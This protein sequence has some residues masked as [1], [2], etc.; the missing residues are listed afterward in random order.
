MFNPQ[1]DPAQ[2]QA[3]SQATGGL[4]DHPLIKYMMEQLA[5]RTGQDIGSSLM[6]PL[7]MATPALDASAGALR[8]SKILNAIIEA[9][10][11]KAPQAI[12]SV[13]EPRLASNRG[14]G[15]VLSR[16]PGFQSSGI[17]SMLQQFMPTQ[18]AMT[19]ARGAPWVLGREIGGPTAM[20][21]QPM[22]ES[23]KVASRGVNVGTPGEILRYILE[24]ISGKPLKP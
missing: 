9:I 6:S 7:G 14:V 2:G 15:T 17:E 10:K 13:G 19:G 20:F 4:Y 12:A 16:A 3:M 22:A 8:S 5:P 11:K 24:A 1:E 23:S 21:G 18:K